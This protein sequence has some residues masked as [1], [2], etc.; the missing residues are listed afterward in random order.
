MSAIR[1]A[2][3][4]VLAALVGAVLASARIGRDHERRIDAIER[5]LAVVETNWAISDATLRRAEDLVGRIERSLKEPSL[6]LPP[7]WAQT[8]WI[9]TNTPWIVPPFDRITN[10]PLPATLV[11]GQDAQGNWQVTNA[12][13]GAQTRS[14]PPT[15]RP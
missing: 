3:G 8:N 1:F 11:L 2:C 7:W 9:V 10:A 14:G 6:P 12:P 4:I 5:R 13:S 15:P